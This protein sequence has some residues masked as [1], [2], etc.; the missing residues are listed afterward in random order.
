MQINYGY[1]HRSLFT[2]V[3][4]CTTVIIMFRSAYESGFYLVLMNVQDF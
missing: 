1:F 2:G 4:N 3:I